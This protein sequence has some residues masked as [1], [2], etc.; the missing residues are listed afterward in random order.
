MRSFG[1]VFSTS[2]LSHRP[3]NWTG[4]DGFYSRLQHGG[5]LGTAGIGKDSE[6]WQVKPRLGTL[7][8]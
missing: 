8:L 2:F 1:P 4:Q 5:Q 3:A 7:H 6:W